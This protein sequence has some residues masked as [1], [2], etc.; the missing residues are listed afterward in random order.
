[1]ADNRIGILIDTQTTGGDQLRQHVQQVTEMN[2]GWSQFNTLRREAAE[3]FPND[4]KKQNTDMR[5]QLG[6]LKELE[7]VG[8]QERVAAL[9]DRIGVIRDRFA[10]GRM[11]TYAKKDIAALNAKI[12]AE[13]VK[14]RDW[15]TTAAE[16]H[17]HQAQWGLDQGIGDPDIMAQMAGA[18]VRGG[19]MGIM[20]QGISSATGLM[21]KKMAGMGVGGKLA[22]GLTAGA[23]LGG[24]A[25]VVTQLSKG[26]DLYKNLAPELLKIAAISGRLPDDAERYRDIF[27]DVANATGTATSEL[28]QYEKQW[29]TILGGNTIGAQGGKTG[30]LASVIDI[31][32]AYGIDKGLGTEFAARMGM[33]GYRSKASDDI[34]K[35]VIAD[36]MASGIGVARLPEYLQGIQQLT[37]V[38]MRTSVTSDPAS[39]SMLASTVGNLGLPFQGAR[40]AELIGGL[41]QG[42]Q[43]GMGFQ[44][45]REIL[46][47]GASLFDIKALQ[48]Q[49]ANSPRMV[50][51]YMS[52]F[53]KMAGVG[54]KTGQDLMKAREYQAILM[55]AETKIP[56]ALLYNPSKKVDSFLELNPDVLQNLKGGDLSDLSESDAAIVQ[57]IMDYKK[58]FGFETQQAA[59][60]ADIGRINAAAASFESTA[61]LFYESVNIIAGMTLPRY[62]EYG[63]FPP[64]DAAT[65]RR[66]IQFAPDSGIPGMVP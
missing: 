10:G 39:L 29:L 59:I 27:L 1:M 23:V 48:Q 47:P 13:Q 49:G 26:W 18:G 42:M 63:P 62:D 6:I 45:A 34:L 60:A 25:F 22:L 15:R 5:T 32:Q 35:Q 37:S 21:T 56:L 66:K 41:H 31:S 53:G 52:L 54:G 58:T 36:G 9:R 40:G 46:G 44:A 14:H 4:I 43:G 12:R 61:R 8:S 3:K 38:V 50:A 19:G 2:A 64:P 57:K 28:L 11:G 55:A 7:M 17:A 20:Q 16:A 30:I 51:G 65:N 33:T 24:A